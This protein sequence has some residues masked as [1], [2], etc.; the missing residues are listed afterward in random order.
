MIKLKAPGEVIFLELCFVCIMLPGMI[1][2]RCYINTVD[3]T[4]YIKQKV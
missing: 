4:K 1:R 2:I 3:D